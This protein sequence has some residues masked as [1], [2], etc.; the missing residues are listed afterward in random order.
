MV[1]VLNFAVG[2]VLPEAPR[3]E[4]H[5]ITYADGKVTQDR[6]VNSDAPVFRMH[7]SAELLDV[8]TG[9]TVPW[10][11]GSGDFP[12]QTG[13]K[14][15]TMPLAVWVGNPDCTPESLPPGRYEPLAVY[16][17]GDKQV[18]GRG[19]VFEVKP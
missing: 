4:V 12:Y 5:A 18:I 19:K 17:W 3:I 6:T 14:A 10:C 2:T 16:A 13:R 9:E 7:W 11:Q 8:A 1:L 15:K